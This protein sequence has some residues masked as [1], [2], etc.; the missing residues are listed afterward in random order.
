M[1]RLDELIKELCPDGVRFVS[2]WSVTIWDKKFNSVGKEKQPVVYDYPYL[3]AAD[4]FSLQRKNGDVFLLSTGEQTGWT[5]EEIAG[6]NMREGE[7][8]TIPWGKSRAV[9]DCIKY[10]KGK[11]VTADNRIMTSNDTSK[12]DNKY[13]YYWMMS[14]GKIIDTF[15]RGSGI[16]HPDMAKV[17]DMSIPVPPLPIQQEIV[18]ILDSF[19]ELT[20]E[21][22]AELEA[23]KKQY[24]YYKLAILNKYIS[25]KTTFVPISSITDVRDGTHESPKQSTEG[26]YLITSKNVKNGSIVFEGS[27]LISNKDYDTINLRSKVNKWDLLFTM[28]GT[29]GEIGLISEEPDF[30]IKNVGLIKVGNETKARFLKYYLTSEYAKHYIETNRSKGTQGF[31][32]L[33]KLRNMP[34]PVLP[35]GEQQEIVDILNKFDM[36]FSDVNNG[37]PAEIAA[38]QKQYEYYRDR[39]LTFKSIEEVTQ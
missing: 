35:F 21:L 23:R 10:F 13:L 1:S 33:G 39:L 19:T 11:F 31:L 8:V 9:T 28:I 34:V 5:T 26:K 14:Q 20:A 17:L 25:S 12:L 22:T 29:V 2:L 15:Y 7:V 16:K 6:S 3:L 27:Y 18:R 32:P 38:R 36:L 30:A 4:L 37:L 24:D